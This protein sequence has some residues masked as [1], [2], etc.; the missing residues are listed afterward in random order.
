MDLL[1]A[2]V[3]ELGHVL[4]RDH[5]DGA[6][7]ETLAAGTRESIVPGVSVGRPAKAAPVARPGWF[8]SGG[9]ARR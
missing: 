9:R 3:H 6:M 8:L 4:G 1:T 2:V 5:G 7:G